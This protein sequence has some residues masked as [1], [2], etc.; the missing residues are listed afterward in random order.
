MDSLDLVYK[1]FST[2]DKNY[3]RSKKTKEEY[4]KSKFGGDIDI[5]AMIILDALTKG[6]V[7]SAEDIEKLSFIRDSFDFLKKNKNRLNSLPS[8][9]PH[10]TVNNSSILE[11]LDSAYLSGTH[12]SVVS[13]EGLGRK[14]AV[15]Y[16]A[17]SKGISVVP[18]DLA[19]TMKAFSPAMID[20]IAKA[21]GQTVEMGSVWERS[22]GNYFTK[23]DS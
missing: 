23:K 21:T 4:I 20:L 6:S 14:G 22:T 1:T 8:F 11:V 17:T 16:V 13:K 18:I 2:L 9:D 3:S 10:A 7:E 5:G 12:I 15:H 19:T